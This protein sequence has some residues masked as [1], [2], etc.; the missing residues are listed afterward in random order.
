MYIRFNYAHFYDK[1]VIFIIG[2]SKR[3]RINDV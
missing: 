1:Y 2:I 3:N